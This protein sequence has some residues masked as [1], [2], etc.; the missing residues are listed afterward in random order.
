MAMTDPDPRHRGRAVLA[1][2]ESGI[3]VA[4]GCLEAEARAMNG[5]FLRRIEMGRPWITAKL[6]MS[7]DARV[8]YSREAPGW[9]TGREARVDTHRLRSE[10]PLIVTGLGTVLADD[11]AL[12]VR[13]YPLGGTPPVRLVIDSRAGLPLDS[14]I[15]AKDTRAGAVWLACVEG[16]PADRLR[17]LEDRGVRLVEC[18]ADDAGK[19]DLSYLSQE[20]GTRFEFNAAWLECGP[21]LMGAFLDQCL[22]DRW[23]AY[24]APRLVGGGTALPAFLGIGARDENCAPVLDRIS[25]LPVGRDMRLTA[26]VVYSRKVEKQI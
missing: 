10:H 24:F 6:G 1:L 19:V 4:V 22:I 13:D 2:E 16:A 3:E 23:V 11:P 12:T 15:L 9:F 18:P 26:D 5:P 8:A 17:P 25:W 21:T 7:A 20:L 14:A